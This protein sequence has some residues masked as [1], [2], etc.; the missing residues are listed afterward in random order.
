MYIKILQQENWKQIK[1]EKNK[2]KNEINQQENWKQ[3]TMIFYQIQL[4]II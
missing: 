3:I 2:M 4:K 1:K